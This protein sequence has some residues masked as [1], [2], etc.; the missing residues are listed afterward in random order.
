MRRLAP[1]KVNLGLE[2][3]GRRADG[4]HE[5][6]TIFQAVGLCDELTIAAAPP[7]QVTLSADPPLAGEANLVLRA[8]RALA[9]QSGSTEGAALALTKR[10][11]VAAGL[12]GGSSDAAATLRGLREFW[13]LTS[14]DDTLARLAQ[15]LGADVP[16]FLRGGTALATGIGEVLTPLPPL[17]PTWFVLLTPT[18]PLPPDKTRQ[19]YRALT[20]DDFSDGTRTIAQ[21]NR[22][23]RGEALDPGLLVNTFAAPLYRLF[24]TLTTWRDRLLAAGA[25]WVLPSGSGP[26]LFTATTSEASGR[27]IAAQVADA[28]ARVSVVPNRVDEPSFAA[29]R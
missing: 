21:S 29:P 25:P 18:L 6:V 27:Q 23:R 8:A 17:A 3:V 28:A 16:F 9:S 19:L 4:Y 11:P 20:P 22:L 24:P 13:G 12:G 26:T 10:I 15:A 2:I 14:D 7:S 1:A 5:L